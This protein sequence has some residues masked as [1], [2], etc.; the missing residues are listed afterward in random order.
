MTYTV[1]TP[2]SYVF[3][4]QTVRPGSGEAASGQRTPEH[5]HA[6]P[7]LKRQKFKQILERENQAQ[8]RDSAVADD[9]PQPNLRLAIEANDDHYYPNRD[10][11][12][13]GPGHGA[14]GSYRPPGAFSPLPPIV[15]PPGISYSPAPAP[16]TPAPYQPPSINYSPAPVTPAPH[17]PPMTATYQPPVATYHPPSVPVYHAPSGLPDTSYH[18]QSRPAYRPFDPPTTISFNPTV[19]QSDLFF[20]PVKKRP[21]RRHHKKFPSH[22][23]NSVAPG[24]KFHF[25][26]D[27][28]SPAA[29]GP[30]KVKRFPAETASSLDV[31][32]RP[33]R[34]GVVALLKAEDLT[35]MAALLEETHLDRSIDKQGQ[36]ISTTLHGLP[37]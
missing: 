2:A 15:P 11:Y 35:V 30:H 18:T 32:P 13:P 6:N 20:Q 37:S 5:N 34:G 33:G 21:P 28:S 3:F 16:V 12:F 7:N 26:E 25:V 29:P 1:T 8:E 14:G 31:G 23:S 22:H 36:S 19:V 17:H 27:F 10:P 24:T 4:Q 9:R